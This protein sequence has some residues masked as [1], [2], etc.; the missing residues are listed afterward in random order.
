MIR[1]AAKGSEYRSRKEEVV[2]GGST[3]KP[4]ERDAESAKGSRKASQG[5]R[6]ASQGS[7]RGSQALRS[8]FEKPAW[9]MQRL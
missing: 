2:P 9:V 5:S 1:V 6:R 7:R 4:G 3:Q 8:A